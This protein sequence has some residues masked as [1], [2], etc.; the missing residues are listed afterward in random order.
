MPSV[1]SFCMGDDSMGRDKPNRACG[2]ILL[3]CFVLSS[4]YTFRKVG[5]RTSDDKMDL[6]CL[7]LSGRS[8]GA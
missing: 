2:I 7:A 3:V 1:G 4:I 6:V 8:S 5:G